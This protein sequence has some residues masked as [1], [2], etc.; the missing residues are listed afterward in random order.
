MDLGPLEEL[1]SWVADRVARAR[2]QAVP[3]AADEHTQA[4]EDSEQRLMGLVAALGL[5][6]APGAA[7]S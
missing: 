3:A 6:H 2:G 4:T 7:G 1:P 5:R